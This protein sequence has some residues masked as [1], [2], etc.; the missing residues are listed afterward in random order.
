MLLHQQIVA[1]QNTVQKRAVVQP[2]HQECMLVD[3]VNNPG[4]HHVH[5]ARK[6]LSKM[7]TMGVNNAFHVNIVMQVSV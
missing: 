5:L 3:I 7:A 6:V 2:V 4:V 1:Q